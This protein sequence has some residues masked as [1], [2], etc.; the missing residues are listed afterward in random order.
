MVKEDKKK[1]HIVKVRTNKANDQRVV[2]IPKDA[3][4]IGEYAEVSKHE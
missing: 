4:E 3:D 1:I 2:T